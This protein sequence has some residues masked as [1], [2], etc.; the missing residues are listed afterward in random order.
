MTNNALAFV[1]E[2]IK[3][4]SLNEAYR[5]TLS[6]QMVPMPAIEASIAVEL[7]RVDRAIGPAGTSM[8]AHLA[9]CITE[10]MIAL[11]AARDVLGTKP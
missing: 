3:A 4:L 7:E 6:G 5:E 11:H 9:E 8:F 10:A 1:N 2:A